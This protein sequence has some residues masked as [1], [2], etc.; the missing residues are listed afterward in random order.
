MCTTV[1]SIH[2]Q[3]AMPPRPGPSQNWCPHEP[4]CHMRLDAACQAIAMRRIINRISRPVLATTVALWALG[5]CL[6]ILGV[7]G[8]ARGWWTPRP[9]LTNVVSGLTTAS[10]GIPV[11]LLVLGELATR[12][13]SHAQQYDYIGRLRTQ[14]RETASAIQRVPR[15]A[16]EVL[17][18]VQLKGPDDPTL[19]LASAIVRGGAEV[20]AINWVELRRQ[21]RPFIEG[22]GAT[23]TMVD[24]LTY[25]I[26]HAVDLLENLAIAF[27]SGGGSQLRFYSDLTENSLELLTTLGKLATATGLDFILLAESTQEPSTASDPD[28]SAQ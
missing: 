24:T 9:F 26:A 7:F 2:G 4:I 23:A 25:D 21:L 14:I 6:A 19:K 18:I 11:A 13:R 16:D 10:F 5:A 1:M 20:V 8:D 28:S 22:K 12:Q 3:T 17:R 27:T 15:A